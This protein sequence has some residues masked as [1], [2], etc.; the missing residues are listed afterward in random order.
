M[1][2][3]LE[4]VSVRL[5][6]RLVLDRVSLAVAPG[7][8]AVVVGGDGAGKSTAMRTLVGLV[9]PDSG[10]VRRPDKGG[11]G[12]LPATSGLYVDLTVAENLEF[13]LSCYGLTGTEFVRRSGELLDRL[14]LGDARDRLAGQ[15]SGGMQRKLGAGIALL[16]KPELVVLDEPT[17]G[18]DPV[19]R[20]D[21]WRMI[22]SAAASGSAVVVAT[23]Y[24][25]EAAR[26]GAVLLLD[27]GR[28]IAAGS[29][30]Q[31]LASVP[32][33]LGHSARRAPA[34]ARSWRRGAQW[35]VWSPSGRLP[36]DSVPVEPAFDDA[37]VIACLADE[38]SPVS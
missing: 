14:D 2:F 35:R 38:S 19:S 13:S 15:L 1:S 25:N 3:G 29:P 10:A 31:I 34:P 20:A 28:T 30:E 32:G 23:T 27:A 4:A 33:L 17:T 7:E 24:V 37:V 8:I 16:H 11:I 21:L 6:S 9:R 26:A 12:Y 22:A 5:G 36:V 18:I